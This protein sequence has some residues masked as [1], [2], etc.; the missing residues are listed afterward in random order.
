[1]AGGVLSAAGP[2]FMGVLFGFAGKI[3]GFR[4]LVYLVV[5]SSTRDIHR[6]PLKGHASFF[7]LFLLLFAV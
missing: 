2:R 6:F 4:F 5:D 3:E 7:L 1:M